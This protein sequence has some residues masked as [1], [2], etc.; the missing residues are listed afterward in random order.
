MH[1]LL[2]K[3]VKLLWGK[4]SSAI[5]PA[6]LFGVA[7]HLADLGAHAHK[8]VWEALPSTSRT[9]EINPSKQT[10]PVGMSVHGLNV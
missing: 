8:Q 3:L 4:M 10:P 6:D 2:I 1:G 5:F 7:I 9:L